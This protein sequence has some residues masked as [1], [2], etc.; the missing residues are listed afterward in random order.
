MWANLMIFPLVVSVCVGCS[1]YSP[2]VKS[3]VVG[4]D[5]V[6]SRRRWDLLGLLRATRYESR[7]LS[8]SSLLRRGLPLPP[9]SSRQPTGNP[10]NAC[11]RFKTT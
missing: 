8:P 6:R 7:Q 2:G 4:F 1:I 11:T 3:V 9:E 5:V 10:I